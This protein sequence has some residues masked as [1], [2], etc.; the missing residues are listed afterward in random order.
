VAQEATAVIALVA[1]V[2]Q[3]SK[4]AF[5]KF[6]SHMRVRADLPRGVTVAVGACNASVCVCV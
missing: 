5:L 6:T 2:F 1:R 4:D 3:Y